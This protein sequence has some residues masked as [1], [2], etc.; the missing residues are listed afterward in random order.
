[1]C[2][3]KIP[4]IKINDTLVERVTNFNFLGFLIDENLS[5]KYHIN[6]I[7]TKIAR[8]IGVMS[9]LKRLVPSYTLKLM[10]NSLILPHIN[11]G[12]TLW[13]HK[14]ERLQKLQKRAVRVLTKSKYNAHTM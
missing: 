4:E 2:R 10:Y 3:I 9:K 11:Y 7:S 12:I 6:K 13:G 14:A 5:W 8:V 1:M